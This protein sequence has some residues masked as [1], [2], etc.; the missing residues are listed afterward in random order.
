MLSVQQAEQLILDSIEPLEETMTVNLF[1]CLGRVLAQN[2]KSDLDFPYWDNSAMDGYAVQYQDVQNCT[3]QNPVSLKIVEEI[4]AGKSPQKKLSQGEAARIFT[5]AMLPEGADTIVIQEESQQ[6]GQQVLILSSP[7]SAGAFVRKKGEFYQAKSPLLN[8]GKRLTPG[9]IPLLALAQCTELEVY[10]RPKVSIFSTGDELRKPGTV[11]QAGEIIDSNQYALAAY[12]Q[13]QGG[14]PLCLGIVP[15]Q[16][17]QLRQT[18]QLAISSADLVFSTAGVS[19]GDYDYVER[20]L[21]ELGG[22]I[23]ISSVAIK[24]GKPLKVASFANGTLY[25]GIPGN[26]VSAL[27]TCWRLITPA[28]KKL[29]G[30]LSN[31]TPQFILARTESLLLSDGKRETYLCGELNIIQGRLEFN[32]TQGSQSSGNLIHLVNTN[33]LAILPI[34]CQKI[35]IGQEVLVISL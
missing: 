35:A 29:A 27:V 21:E 31:W 30:E 20:I 14:E 10:R 22:Q 5:G 34:G 6:Q 4:A 7:K 26:P 24:P 8:A 11:L 28:L 3:G 1:N 17:D 25:F 18:M 15:D 13:E 32:L 16:V 9:D 23:L 12:V 19:V 33:A 2:I